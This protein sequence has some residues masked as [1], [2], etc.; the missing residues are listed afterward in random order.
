MSTKGRAGGKKTGGRQKGTPNKT[1]VAVKE[2]MIEA[3]DRLGGADYLVELG[4]K[5]PRTFG[6]L[7]AKLIPAE[8]HAQVNLSDISGRLERGRERVMID[9]TPKDD[10][11]D[12]V[13]H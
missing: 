5:E 8:V 3:F 10:D 4:R 11:N 12:A 7:L 9:V 13:V 6:A 2:V 1:T